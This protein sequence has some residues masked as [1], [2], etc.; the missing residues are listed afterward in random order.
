MGESLL[1]TWGE[2]EAGEEAGV[3]PGSS[4]ETARSGF[5]PRRPT[6]LNMHGLWHPGA[7]KGSG[8]GTYLP[9]I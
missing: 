8:S 7:K 9:I 1:S 6:I 3:P 5:S 2:L 4:P